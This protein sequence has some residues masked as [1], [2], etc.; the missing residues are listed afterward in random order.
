MII[1]FSKDNCVQCTWTKNLLNQ[2][3]LPYT[4]INLDEPANEDLRHELAG[5][6]PRQ[7]PLVQT[8]TG[9]WSGF[10]PDKIRAL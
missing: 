3:R 2:R 6:G 7:M 9:S 1:V 5:A 10:S 4:E 8:P